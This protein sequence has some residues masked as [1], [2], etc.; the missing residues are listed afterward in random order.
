M[1]RSGDE[2]K[3]LHGILVGLSSLR[4]ISVELSRASTAFAPRKTAAASVVDVYQSS[5]WALKS[6]IIRMSSVGLNKVW[7][8]GRY[9]GGQE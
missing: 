9:D 1:V 7:K 8:S 6:P 2:G 3:P 4:T 5:S